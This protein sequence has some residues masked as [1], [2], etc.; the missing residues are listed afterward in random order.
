[1]PTLTYVELQRLERNEHVKSVDL[2]QIA[3]RRLSSSQPKSDEL[4]FIRISLNPGD[5]TIAAY[6]SS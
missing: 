5:R 1:M 6:H 3:E 4:V 2:R